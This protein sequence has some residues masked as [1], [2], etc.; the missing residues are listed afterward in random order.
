MNRRERVVLVA[1]LLA[2]TAVAAAA[3]GAGT[4]GAGAPADASTDRTLVDSRADGIVPMLSADAGLPSAD[5]APGWTPRS[6]GVVDASVV[7]D[8]GFRWGPCFVTD[9]AELA[10]E[11]SSDCA[12]QSN[13]SCCGVATFGVNRSAPFVGC[14]GPPC[15]PPRD[16]QPACFQYYTQD[17]R[18]VDAASAVVAVCVDHRCM[19]QAAP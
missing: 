10:C 4:S 5:A 6:A 9:A 12:W 3:C 19:T 18:A 14:P 8:G 16:Y 15:P 2:G 17:C 1:V 7:C 13:G 11:A